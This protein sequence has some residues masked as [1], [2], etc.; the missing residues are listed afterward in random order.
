MDAGCLM[1]VPSDN[2][3]RTGID[4]EVYTS[5]GCTQKLSKCLGLG[6]SLCYDE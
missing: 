6:S 5:T 2:E 3:N 4:G 1:E